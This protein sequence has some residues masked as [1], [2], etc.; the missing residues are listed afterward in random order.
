MF[1]SHCTGLGITLDHW[2]GTD[3]KKGGGQISLFLHCSWVRFVAIPRADKSD[4][5]VINPVAPAEAMPSGP[6]GASSS[7]G[8]AAPGVLLP[9]GACG[10]GSTTKSGCNCRPHCQRATITSEPVS[11]SIVA[12]QSAFSVQ[13]Q[14]VP[15]TLPMVSRMATPISGA[16]AASYS[17]TAGPHATPPKGGSFR[18]GV[19]RCDSASLRAARLLVRSRV[20]P[21]R[22]L[23]YYRQPSK[24]DCYFWSGGPHFR[25][26]G[27][28]VTAPM[29]F[30]SK[31]IGRSPER[32]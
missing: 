30:M 1:P 26:A 8:H 21:V 24:S 7:S 22:Q 6:C 18:V 11:R 5:S 4:L 12:G 17:V 31:W 3:T 25:I 23:L 28:Q 16:I 32:L 14:P 29:T 19:N 13:P 10:H 20:A 2:P 9:Q 15:L 27:P